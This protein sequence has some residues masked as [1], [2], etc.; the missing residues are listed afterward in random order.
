METNR[1]RM[2]KPYRMQL[3]ANK[4]LILATQDICAICGKPV[5]KTLRSPDPMSPSID[6]IIPIAKGGHPCDISNLQLAHRACN[7]AKGTKIINDTR[8]E[9][10]EAN[11]NLPHSRNWLTD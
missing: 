3:E 11:R 6:H 2:V 8:P 5:D 9:N 7:R 1:W 4:R 10:K